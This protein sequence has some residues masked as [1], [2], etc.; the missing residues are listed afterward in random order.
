MST[1]NSLDVMRQFLDEVQSRH[2][3]KGAAEDNSVSFKDTND[4]KPEVQAQQSPGSPEQQ[5]L[6]VEQ[7]NDAHDGGANADSVEPN[8]EADGKD[9][10][11]NAGI[12]TLST[13]DK[14]VDK[15]NIGPMRG[16]AITQEQKMA[17]ADR[18]ADSI[19]TVLERSLQK[20]AEEGGSYPQ[21]EDWNSEAETAKDKNEQF[22]DS[23]NGEHGNEY[24]DAM[25]SEEDKE[26]AAQ[27]NKIAAVAQNAAQD[28]YEGFIL[29]MLKRAQD[30][31]DLR[32]ANLPPAV[33]QKVGG[34][35][36]LLDKVAMADPM[37]VLPEEAMGGAP[38]EAP[39]EEAPMEGGGE[40]L[41]AIAG[42]LDAAGVTPEDLEAAM[43]DVAALQEAGVAPEEIAAALTELEGEGG[44]EAAPAMEAPEAPAEGGAEAPAEEEKVASGL[45]RARVNWVKA[46][47]SK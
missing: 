43:A 28:Y 41:D 6:G 25:A 30:E 36:G 29:G 33:L 11:D 2:M 32:A 31:A 20:K 3:Q 40:D 27:F 14:V 37:A 44:G 18:L 9:Y 45:S 12:N 13:D 46:Y 17:R 23:K 47:L 38:E 26:A 7:K 22:G 24:A 35:E 15:G 16:Q 34:I 21:D 1:G 19:L 8:S 10:A 42:E 39:M 4:A 5:T